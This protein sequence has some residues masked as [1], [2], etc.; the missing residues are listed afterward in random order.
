MEQEQEREPEPANA[1][2]RAR[3]PRDVLRAPAGA[4]GP[5]LGRWGERALCR[6]AAPCGPMTLSFPKASPIKC[7]AARTTWPGA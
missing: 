7:R 1:R 2:A 5:R 6:L 3:K 4:A